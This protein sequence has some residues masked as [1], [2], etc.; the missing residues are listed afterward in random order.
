VIDLREAQDETPENRLE[1]HRE[2]LD[3]LFHGK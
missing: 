3:R 2:I 1:I